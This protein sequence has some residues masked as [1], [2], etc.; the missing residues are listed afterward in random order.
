MTVSSLSDG[1]PVVSHLPPSDEARLQQAQR[2]LLTKRQADLEFR[3]VLRESEQRPLPF[4]SVLSRP[5]VKLPTPIASPRPAKVI[6]T[7]RVPHAQPEV[8][9]LDRTQRALTLAE[10]HFA[11]LRPGVHDR[12][13]TVYAALV[14]AA[15]TLVALRGHSEHVTSYVYFT[16]LDAL[17]VATNLSA[18][19]C[20]R[21]LSDLRDVGLVHTRRWYTSAR[22]P[23]ADGTFE[24]QRCCGGVFVCVLLRA[25]VGARAHLR[26]EDL[27]A[28][29]RDLDADRKRGRTAWQ[30]RK[31]VAEKRVRESSSYPDRKVGIKGL[32]QWT[33]EN[34]TSTPSVGV[35]SLTAANDPA[36]VVWNLSAVL[37]TT[38]QARGDAIEAAATALARLYRDPGSIKHY[39]R[40]LHRAVTA[41]FQGIPALSRLQFTL[42]RV[43][44]HMRETP[45]RRP[46]AIIIRELKLSGWWNEVYRAA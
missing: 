36:D 17:P 8:D 5:P 18:A 10:A 4:P 9:V 16:V 15:Y 30:L 23:T 2:D 25:R 39:C 38:P 24:P 34:P 3:R 31:E 33:L 26:P 35:D 29:P 46:G 28:A 21:A 11:R 6:P 37:S 32:L 7:R 40:L 13:R 1:H 43:L 19:T 44:I 20:E 22:F 12:A 14:E 41:E 42:Q 27:T 45:P